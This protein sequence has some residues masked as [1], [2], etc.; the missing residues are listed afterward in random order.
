MNISF[1]WIR[2]ELYK[3][4]LMNQQYCAES[5]HVYMSANYFIRLW[6]CI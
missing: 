5:R 2:K 6:M 4:F 3:C 1:T